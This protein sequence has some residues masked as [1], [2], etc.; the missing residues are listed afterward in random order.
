MSCRTLPTERLK[1]QIDTGGLFVLQECSAALRIAKNYKFGWAQQQPD[2]GSPSCVIDARNGVSGD[3]WK[4]L[5]IHSAP[6]SA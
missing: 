2:R 4:R 3:H 6:D 1:G 5:R